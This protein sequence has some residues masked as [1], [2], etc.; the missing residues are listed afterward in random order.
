M[1]QEVGLGES[2][3]RVLQSTN[4]RHEGV[5]SLKLVKDTNNKIPK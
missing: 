5:E 2:G 4:Q 3:R 1:K